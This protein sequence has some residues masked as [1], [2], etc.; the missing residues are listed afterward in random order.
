MKILALDLEGTLISNAMSQ[1]V[2]P[3]LKYFLEEVNVEFDKIVI[4]TAVSEEKYNEILSLLLKEKSV[5]DWFKDVEYIKWSGKHKDLNYICN[6][7]DNVFIVDDCE[8][9]ILPEQKLQWIR[10]NQYEYP[11]SNE[12]NELLNILKVIKKATF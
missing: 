8:D 1:I 9:Y 5:P 6:E 7:I 12:D 4:Y 3:H 11:Y 10:I 2:R